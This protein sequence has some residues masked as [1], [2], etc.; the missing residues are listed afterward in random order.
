MRPIG[1]AVPSARP[2]PFERSE[3]VMGVRDFK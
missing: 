2:W 3:P 1:S